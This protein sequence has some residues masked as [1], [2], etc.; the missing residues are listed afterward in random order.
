MPVP[1]AS[2]PSMPGYGISESDEGLLP[3]SWATERLAA[4]RNYWV[5]TVRPDGSPHAMAVW[6]VWSDDVYWFNTSRRSR[7]ARNLAA[8]ARCVVTTENADECV[9]LEGQASC[10]EDADSLA[11]IFEIYERK[12]GFDLATMDSPT[13]AV[14]PRVVFGFIEAADA[15]PG[16]ATRWNF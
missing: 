7:K 12:Y 14:R 2:R 10:V 16:S 4:S 5:S 1:N 3:W 8:D 6:G 11:R 13:Y 15:F 9:I